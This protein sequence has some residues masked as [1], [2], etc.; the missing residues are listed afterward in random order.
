M[1][2]A[3]RVSGFVALHSAR[4]GRIVEGHNQCPTSWR[5]NSQ[6]R[7]RGSCDPHPVRR[8]ERALRLDALYGVFVIT[9]PVGVITYQ[10]PPFRFW[11]CPDAV[12]GAE[13]PTYVYRGHPAYVTT[14]PP[15]GF[16]SL[17]SS[18]ALSCFAA[19]GAAPAER[20]TGGHTDAH[21]PTHVTL[22]LLSG[23]KV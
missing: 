20:V 8:D 1:L 11:A 14:L 9:L 10:R 2:T 17:E 16:G 15:D 3:Q 5:S 4:G 19:A 6:Q 18:D 21:E 12:P 22:L 13:S 23:A 7:L